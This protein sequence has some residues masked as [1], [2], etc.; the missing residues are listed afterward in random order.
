[1]IFGARQQE[2]DL[3]T[4]T[5]ATTRQKR[6]RGE[7]RTFAVTL[8]V[9]ALL[10]FVVFAWVYGPAYVA[11]WNYAPREGDIVF[12]S[13]PR[14]RLV[15]AIEGGSQSPYSHCGI[16]AK[17]NGGWV[18]YEAYR[19]VAA[20]PLKEFIF[21]GR[22]KGF[23]VYRFKQAYRKHIPATIE[24][25]RK[26]LGRPYDVRYRM[27]DDSIYCSELIYKAYRNAS[28]GQQLGTLVRLGD[29]NW[30]PYESTIKHF[31]RGPAPL[32]RIMITPKHLAQASQ[33]ELAF[34]HNIAVAN[35]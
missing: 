11:Y 21:R 20:T 32:D 22:D 31:E 33:L 5:V 12:Q 8:A 10:A 26:Y 34:S 7:R 28:G 24:N 4:A 2:Y 19:N 27:D 3:T 14:S 35:P 23:A 29:L 6:K 30:R 1:M 25:T 15:N 18:V 9:C 17:Q 13:L 16:V